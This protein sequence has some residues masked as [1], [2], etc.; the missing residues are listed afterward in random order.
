MLA[1]FLD[2][3]SQLC[4]R[5]MYKRLRGFGSVKCLWECGLTKSSIVLSRQVTQTCILPSKSNL[6]PMPQASF[7]QSSQFRAR[8]IRP[9]GF[10]S[11][12]RLRECGL[13]KSSI[14]L[15]HQVTQ[16]LHNLPSKRNLLPM[17]A[18]F[19]YSPTPYVPLKIPHYIFSLWHHKKCMRSISN[20][21]LRCSISYFWDEC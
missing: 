3:S 21:S 7:D 14:V 13:T 15:S 9:R 17:L 11:V 4:W 2:Q 18:G 1:G 5:R 20:N 10:G 16:T 6:L 19:C 12:K 8:R